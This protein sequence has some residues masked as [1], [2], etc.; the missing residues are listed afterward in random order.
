M[1][2]KI[3]AHTDF[4]SRVYNIYIELLKAIKEHKRNFEESR[5]EMGIITGALQSFL[6]C[7]QKDKEPLLDYTKRFKTSRE[8]MQSHLGG[9]IIFEELCSRI[10]R[11]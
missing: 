3:E 2:G 9:A 8:I 10:T 5:Y 4:Q 6:S 7:R 1:Q 11:L